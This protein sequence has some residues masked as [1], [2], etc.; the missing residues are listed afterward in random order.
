MKNTWK[1]ITL[2]FGVAIML[3]ACNTNQ[4]GAVGDDGT[5]IDN[6]SHHPTDVDDPSVIPSETGDKTETTNK[7][8]STYNGMGNDIYGS[9]GSSGIYEGGLSSYFG[10]VLEGEGITGV[11]VFVVDDS[12][13]LAR[14]KEQTTSHEYDDLQNDVL[15]GTEGM[16]GKGEPQGV[17]D[18][19]KKVSHDNLAQAKA[20]IKKMFNGNVKILTV[21][22]PAA[23]DLIKSI[24]ENIKSESYQTAS[25][26]ILTLFQMTKK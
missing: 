15:S 19:P 3:S 25:N 17:E 10:S 16:S 4:E 22:D 18:S 2:V 26:E 24:K 14:S 11:E 1:K 21:T 6:V 8:D 9:I 12:V 23:L 5:N 13:I 20:Q 7:H